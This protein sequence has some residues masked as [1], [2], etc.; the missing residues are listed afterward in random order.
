MGLEG[1]GREGEERRGEERG[2]NG[3]D[4]FDRYK[5]FEV[6]DK[7][8]KTLKNKDTKL[9]SSTCVDFV[10]A[11]VNQ[12]ISK[13]ALCPSKEALAD[14]KFKR[15]FVHLYGETVTLV[16]PSKPADK[17]M[18]DAAY[19]AASAQLDQIRKTVAAA[20]NSNSSSDLPN[21]QPKQAFDIDAI[22]GMLTK[23][24]AP[25]T[26]FPVFVDDKTTVMVKVAAPFIDNEYAPYK[27]EKCSSAD[28]S[29]DKSKD[30]DKSKD[31]SGS[32][33][34]QPNA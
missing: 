30:K 18:I 1:G 26:A 23:L 19:K 11:V 27:T 12:L 25:Q 6:V 3:T 7:Q 9:K 34:L 10:E 21:N 20:R 24:P 2:T 5:L 32:G 33:A 17:A 29:A 31:N 4:R 28:K 8:K 22:K 14:P 13:K 16:D 15:D